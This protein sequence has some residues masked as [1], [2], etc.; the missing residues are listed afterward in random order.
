ME[1]RILVVSYWLGVLCTVLALICRG[2]MAANVMPPQFGLAGGLLVSYN[3]F[4]HGAGLFLLL[5]IAT[6]CKS[7]IKS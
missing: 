6:W 4:F 5:T 2:F 1:K 7:A 3:S